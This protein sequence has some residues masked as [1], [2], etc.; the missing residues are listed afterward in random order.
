MSVSSRSSTTSPDSHFPSTPVPLNRTHRKINIQVD[1][2]V[3]KK[4]R[5]PNFQFQFPISMQISVCVDEGRQLHD[6]DRS[7]LIRDCVVCLKATYRTITEE[8]LELA[9]KQM[10]EKVP[11]LKDEEPPAWPSKQCFKYWVSVST[12]SMM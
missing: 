1:D 8:I 3:P 12:F 2:V 5:I 11:L 10:C 9:A 4:P 6:S 7:K